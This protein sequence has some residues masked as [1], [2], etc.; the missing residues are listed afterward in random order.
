MSKTLLKNARMINEQEI[1]ERDVL[2]SGSNIEKIDPTIS[3]S[4][5]RVIDIE[6]NYLLPGIIDD[7]VHFREPGLTHKGNIATESR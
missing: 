4:K 3:D 5:A 6:G 2:I 7:Q 1:L